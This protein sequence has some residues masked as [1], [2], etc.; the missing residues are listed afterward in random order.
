MA[1]SISRKDHQFSHCVEGRQCHSS[2]LHQQTRETV[3]QISVSVPT[4]SR[5]LHL[6][7]QLN[8]RPHCKMQSKKAKHCQGSANTPHSGYSSRMVSASLSIWKNMQGL[9]ETDG[10]SHHNPRNHKLTVYVPSS[11]SLGLEGGCSSAS[12][13]LP[14]SV[15]IPPFCR[16]KKD[17]EQIYSTKPLNH[18]PHGIFVATEV[19]VS[20]PLVSAGGGP[21]ST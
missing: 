19:V 12:S 11:S 8:G 4:R 17:G 13:G 7:R 14:K 9:Q 15:G 16:D 1:L 20:G 18:N 2:G 10:E 21:P 5:E 6:D 3:S